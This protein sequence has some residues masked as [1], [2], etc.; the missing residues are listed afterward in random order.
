[1]R[2]DERPVMGYG[3]IAALGL[4]PEPAAGV[5]ARYAQGLRDI[6]LPGGPTLSGAFRARSFDVPA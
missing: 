3:T 6:S 1:M 4:T 2:L 5:L